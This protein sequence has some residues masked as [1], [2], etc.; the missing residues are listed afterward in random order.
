M[1]AGR[2]LP[3]A[4]LGALLPGDMHAIARFAARQGR[5]RLQ[6]V[7]LDRGRTTA[8]L[9]MAATCVCIERRGDGLVARMVS[10]GTPI[11]SGSVDDLLA[12]LW[13]RISVSSVTAAPGQACAPGGNREARLEESRVPPDRLAAGG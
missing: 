1:P 9:E 8:L 12:A 2:V 5:A 10:G 4:H 7:G 6:F 3:F 13:A 11:S